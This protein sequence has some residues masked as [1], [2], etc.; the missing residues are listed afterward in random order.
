MSESK[1]KEVQETV[2]A[3]QRVSE[4][5][6]STLENIE[7]EK[8]L[9]QDEQD[10]MVAEPDN[11]DLRA[12]QN[13]LAALSIFDRIPYFDIDESLELKIANLKMN[14]FTSKRK[15]ELFR[16]HKGDQEKLISSRRKET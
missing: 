2:R 6:I 3:L 11:E 4:A 10:E 13:G 14:Q 16:K 1:D 5:L 15:D 12:V 9:I 8:Y 7:T